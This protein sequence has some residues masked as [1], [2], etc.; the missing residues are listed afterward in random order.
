LL[1]QAGEFIQ[2]RFVMPVLQAVWTVFI[3]KGLKMNL[4]RA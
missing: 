1:K 3:E 4:A 2:M